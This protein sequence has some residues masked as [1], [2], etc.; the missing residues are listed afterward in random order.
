SEKGLTPD[1]VI[2]DM[3]SF[4]KPENVDFEVVHDPGQETNDLEKALGL[5]VEKGAKTCH[6]LGAF[7]L[8]MDHSLKNLSVMKQFHPK[9]E[10]LIY[11]DEVFD[12][13]MVADQYA[14]KAK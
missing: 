12:A 10:K 1:L 3:D 7:G 9:F 4:Q 11:R 6:V 5:A 13:R 14:A 8:R 2:G